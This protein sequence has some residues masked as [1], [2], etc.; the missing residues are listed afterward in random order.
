MS[1]PKNE[2]LLDLC[3]G[4][5]RHLIA[6]HKIGYRHII[7]LDLSEDLLKFAAVELSKVGARHIKLIQEDMRD[8]PYKNYFGVILSLFTS[9][10]YFEHDEDNLKVICREG[11]ALKPNG[12]FILDYMNR[13]YGIKNL[14]VDT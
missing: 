6:L 8:I 14:I 10:G 2:F 12:I 5:G 9:F 4:A 3:C 7:G 11:K 1:I 13:E